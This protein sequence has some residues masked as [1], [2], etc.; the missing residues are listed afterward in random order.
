MNMMTIEEAKSVIKE[1]YFN[2]NGDKT[3]VM[4]LGKSGV[5]KTEGTI[6]LAKEIAKELGKEFVVFTTDKV[7]EL[8]KE[9]DRYFVY[10]EFLLTQ[11]APEDFIGMPRDSADYIVYKPLA[12]AKVLSV[13]SGILFLDEFTNVQRTDV[14]SSVLKILLEKLVGFTKLSNGV[15]VIAAGNTAADSDLAVDRLPEPIRRGRVVLFNISLPNFDEWVE[16]MNKKYGEEWDKRIALF[17]RKFPD[18]FFEDVSREDD[19]YSPKASPRTWSR[20]ASLSYR[21]SDK[22]REKLFYGLLGSELATVLNAFLNTKVPDLNVLN[23]N[24]I[25]W[26]ALGTDSKYF[27]ILELSN[28][29]EN[30]L[31]NY[32]PIIKYLSE[33]DR[34]WLVLM[35]LFISDENKRKRVALQLKKDC[36]EAFKVLLE[37]SA[38]AKK[39]L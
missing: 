6:Q 17:L 36:P 22:A 34:E 23:S 15:M 33:N 2:G 3:S 11:S 29:K 31:S 19:G 30:E 27:A 1:I 37:V 7:E 9:P 24:P 14:Q 35:F 13:C 8:L 39:L 16:Y 25:D 4:L 32:V 10:V 5:G 20:V 26:R 18:K 28:V 38:L 21:L 12:W